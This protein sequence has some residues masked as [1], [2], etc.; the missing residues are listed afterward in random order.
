MDRISM[1]GGISLREMSGMQ[2]DRIVE[3][4]PLYRENGRA[5]TARS[6]AGLIEPAL[7]GRIMVWL[8]M[9]A[10]R[11]ARRRLALEPRYN[12]FAVAFEASRRV[13]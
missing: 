11:R 7:A 13:A 10:M 6:L 1:S 4:D 3:N 2:R 9:A 5:V 8:R 12:S